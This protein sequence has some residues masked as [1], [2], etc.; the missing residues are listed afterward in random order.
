MPWLSVD[1]PDYCCACNEHESMH[2]IVV[3]TSCH[4]REFSGMT[5]YSYCDICGRDCFDNKL[6]TDI[7]KVS[8]NREELMV[9]MIQNS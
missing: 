2:F 7:T 5:I 4:I 1:I 9:F 3:D 8:Y 6:G